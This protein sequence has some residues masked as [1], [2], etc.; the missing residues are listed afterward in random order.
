MK[1]NTIYNLSG[2][3]DKLSSLEISGEAPDGLEIRLF[4]DKGAMGRG[5]ILTDRRTAYDFKEVPGT[6]PGGTEQVSSTKR[7]GFTTQKS[8]YESK[9]LNDKVSSF[10]VDW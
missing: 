1:K 5:W 2:L 4:E 8:F 7:T 3:N 10:T 6:T 9:V